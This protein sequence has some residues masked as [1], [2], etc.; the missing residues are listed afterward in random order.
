MELTVQ[1]V[2]HADDET[3]TVVREAFI[4]QREEPTDPRAPGVDSHR[5]S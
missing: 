3:E 5:L 4:V 2:M 1:V